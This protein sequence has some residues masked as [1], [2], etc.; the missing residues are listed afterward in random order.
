MT[1]GNA[2]TARACVRACMR[3]FVRACVR[4]CVRACVRT[5]VRACVRTCVR[6]CVR[7]CGHKNGTAR[8]G[9]G[10]AHSF[11]RR[12]PGAHSN[13]LKVQ[14]NTHEHA[15]EAFGTKSVPG[16][17]ILAKSIHQSSNDLNKKTARHKPQTKKARQRQT[18][19]TL[20]QTQR[21]D[22]SLT[23][24]ASTC[25]TKTPQPRHHQVQQQPYRNMRRPRA[26]LIL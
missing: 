10:R 8:H 22:T 4:P 18:S 16:R 19:T 15:H 11:L 17:T 13:L 5:C 7:A 2:C 1:Q 26:T 21:P 12:A 25:R 6:A 3:A 14:D 24:P 20:V 23:M 9:P